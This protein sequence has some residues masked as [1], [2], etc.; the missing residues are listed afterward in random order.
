MS[1]KLET[2]YIGNF[3]NFLYRVVVSTLNVKRDV[4]HHVDGVT[5]CTI[6]DKQIMITKFYLSTVRKVK[7]TNMSS[8][9][10]L[11]LPS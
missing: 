6:Q 2:V 9:S 8:Q 10:N 7:H 1:R 5:V 3:L 11:V 4:K